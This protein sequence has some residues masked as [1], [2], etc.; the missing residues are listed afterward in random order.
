M[1]RLI[2]SFMVVTSS[3][4]SR[5][6]ERGMSRTVAFRRSRSDGEPFIG[7]G[8]VHQHAEALVGLQHEMGRGGQN[9]FEGRKPLAHERRHLPQRATLH[10]QQQVVRAAHRS[11]E[12]TSELQSPMDLV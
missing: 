3:K 7:A 6:P 2:T 1:P 10:E 4:K 8:L 12:H 5:M 11:E 9:A